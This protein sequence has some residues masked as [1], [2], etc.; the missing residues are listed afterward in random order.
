MPFAVVVYFLPMKLLVLAQ[1]P[2]PVHGQSIM[3][4]T[5]VEG[6][7][8]VAPDIEVYHVNPALSRDAADVGRIRP[9]K[10]FALL[11][12]CFRALS[13]RWWHGPMWLYYVPAPGKRAALYRDWLAMLWCRPFFSG[14]I[15]HWHACGLGEWLAARAAA[16][17]RGLARLFLGRAALSIVLAPELAA[18]ARLLAPRRL[19]VVANGLDC[20]PADG[21]EAAPPDAAVAAGSPPRRILYL[22]LCSREKGLFVA[23]D[24]LSELNAAPQPSAFPAY[25]LTVAGEFASGAE[26]AEFFRRLAGSPTLASSVDYAGP[27]ADAQKH[28]LLAAADV[29][30]MPTRYPHEGQPLVLI[31]AMAHDLPIVAT[32]WR[33]IPGMLPAACRAWLVSPD[34]SPRELAAALR[35]ACDGGRAQGRLRAH[36]EACFSRETHL[37]ALARALREGLKGK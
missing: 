1:T 28:A 2:P 32:R 35:A 33:A 34:T 18:D 21:G 29:F 10:F 12:A 36:Y 16:P 20:R 23:L 22:G 26:R 9:G 17:E 3:V 14:L 6:L 24:A 31:E 4:R 13:L 25:R 37:R 30:C 11:R 5:L 7:K 15:L 19:R 8:T 27:S